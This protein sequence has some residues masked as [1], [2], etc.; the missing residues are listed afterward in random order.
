MLEAGASSP[1]LLSPQLSSLLG[2]WVVGV[3]RVTLAHFGNF[4]LFGLPAL[5]AAYESVLLRP[6][7]D[8]M[9]VCASSLSSRPPNLPKTH[10][11]TLALLLLLL[12]LLLVP[13]SET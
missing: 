3:G 9:A 6:S 1:L 8:G 4:G 5:P 11:A 10:S 2:A 7:F 12:L 13:L